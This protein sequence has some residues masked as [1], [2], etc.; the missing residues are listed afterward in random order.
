MVVEHVGVGTKVSPISY[1]IMCNHIKK[2]ITNIDQVIFVF[3]YTA[4]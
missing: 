2:E 3:I 4:I 1:A